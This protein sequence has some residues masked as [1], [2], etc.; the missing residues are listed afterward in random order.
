MAESAQIQKMSHKHEAILNYILANPTE[1]MGN[2]A[3]YFGVT[4]SWLSTIVHSHAFQD[5][6]S[7]RKDEMFDSHI[8]QG[9]GDKLTAAANVTLEAYLEK[10][11]TLTPDQLIS[12]SDKIL[13]RLG[14]GSKGAAGTTINGNVVQN[15]QNN[16][17]SKD[18]LEEARSRIGQTQVGQDDSPAALPSAPAKEGVEVE[19]VAVRESSQ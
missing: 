19:G 16:H 2:V 3:G 14:Y 6:L 5:Q 17:V 11:P 13:N 1:P 8:L 9:V 18:V 15:I 12:A 4:F 10:V 7:R